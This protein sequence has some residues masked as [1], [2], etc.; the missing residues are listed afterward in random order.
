MKNLIIFEPDLVGVLLVNEEQVGNT[1][2]LNITTDDTA[3]Q[4]L[5]V[6]KGNVALDDI[7]LESGALNVVELTAS[8]WAL[9]KVTTVGLFK[10]IGAE[11]P[12]AQFV[13]R[14]PEILDT[15]S[16]LSGGNGVYT[17]QGSSSTD[18]LIE[19]LQQSIMTLSVNAVDYIM[20]SAVDNSAIADGATH[21]V[22]TFEFEAKQEDEKTSFYS[23]LTYDI[24]TAV[25]TVNDIYTDCD[26]TVTYK[27]D[28]ATLG[29]SHYAYGDGDKILALNYLLQNFSIGNHTFVV[30]I[31]SEGGTLGGNNFQIISAYLLA[32]ASVAEGYADE[33]EITDESWSGDG[34]FYP[35]VLPEGLDNEDL[36]EEAHE[37]GA[38]EGLIK[39]ALGPASSDQSGSVQSLSE[40]FNTK[41]MLC[42]G[43]HYFEPFY[44]TNGYYR[45]DGTHGMEDGTGGKIGRTSGVFYI[46]IKRITGYH[47]FKFTAKTIKNNGLNHGV[48]FNRISAGVGYV[49]SN[50]VM[51]TASSPQEASVTDWTEYS[52]GISMLP[53]VDYIILSGSDGSPAY[54]NLYFVR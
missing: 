13:I 3:D 1:I 54:K 52:V 5:G 47:F 48:D 14:F 45:K 23:Q 40:F 31:T 17:M 46:P 36:S 15:D 24:E 25:D 22:L 37:T 30:T 7:P 11:E 20:P 27:L 6:M 12:A 38:A 53:Y 28:G 42:V 8:M 2:I 41:Y 29:I 43:Q 49:D 32:A 21:T 39:Y 18:H 26:I 44:R 9:G 33:Y 35:D 51:H 10:G 19:Q 34:E 50:G 16:S 4:W